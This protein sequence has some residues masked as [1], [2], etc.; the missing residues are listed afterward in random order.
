MGLREQHQKNGFFGFIASLWSFSVHLATIGFVVIF[1]EACSSSMAPY[2]RTDA[3]VDREIAYLGEPEVICVQGEYQLF[4]GRS[5]RVP[6]SH[7]STFPHAAHPIVSSQASPDDIQELQAMLGGMTDITGIAYDPVEGSFILIGP[8]AE[9]NSVL[10]AQDWIVAFQSIYAGE[11]PAVSIDPGPDPNHM[12]VHYFGPVENTRFGLVM[13]EADRLLKLLSSGY[14]NSTCSR[15]HVSAPAFKTK[16]ALLTEQIVTARYD[17]WE[18]LWFV[19]RKM[20]VQEG[21]KEGHALFL[22]VPVEVRREVVEALGGSETTESASQAFVNYLNQNYDMLAREV[23]VLRDLRYIAK[24][25]ALAR[26]FADKNVIVDEPWLTY[27]VAGYSTPSTTPANTVVW[28]GPRGPVLVTLGLYGGVD[29]STPNTYVRDVDQVD[30]FLNA[31]LAAR[32]HLGAH[33]WVLNYQG[34][35]YRAWMYHYLRPVHV[36]PL[37]TRRTSIPPPERIPMFPWFWTP[38]GTPPEAFSLTLANQSGR[39]MTIWVIDA[40]SGQPV[41]TVHL[42]HG[43]ASEPQDLSPGTYNSEIVFDDEPDAVYEGKP[44]TLASNVAGTLMIQPGIGEG[45]RKKRLRR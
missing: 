14:D 13:F 7:G 6:Q 22:P 10:N 5:I 11:D 31:V 19:P 8:D 42:A 39:A 1:I 3:V 40:A 37:S 35:R 41:W 12:I 25:A 18:R 17:I 20:L 24:F 15:V 34:V 26:W 27:Q 38:S 4:A 9:S 28:K 36:R 32:P 21:S 45:L 30:P 16:L 43:A 2:P 44:Y 23:P 33:T 29:L